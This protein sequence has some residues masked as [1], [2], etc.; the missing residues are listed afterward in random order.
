[1]KTPKGLYCRY[2][3]PPEV[4]QYA[5]RL[6]HRFSLSLRD[7]ED[8][9]AERGIQVS[10]ETIRRWCIKFGSKYASRLRMNNGEYGDTWYVDEV[11]VRIDSRHRYLY[12]AVD[13]DGDVIDIFVQEKRDARAAKTFFRR[14]VKRNGGTPRVVVTDKLRSYPPALQDTMPDSIHVTERYSNNRAER[15]H[16]STRQRERRMRRFKSITQAQR[17]LSIHAAVQNLFNLGRHL[18]AAKNYRLFRLR[19]FVSWQNVTVG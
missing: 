7:I 12:R 2:R 10:Y 17:F 18:L 3:F 19:A 4:I 5:V 13:Q 9:L 1:M 8:L 14:L 16:Q 15:S 6:Y 11:F